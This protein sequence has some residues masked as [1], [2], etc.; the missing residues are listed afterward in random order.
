MTLNSMGRQKTVLLKGRRR[1][2]S[3][4]NKGV[5]KQFV[6]K[7]KRRVLVRKPPYLEHSKTSQRTEN[8][9]GAK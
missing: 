3:K 5:R 9:E 2:V 7:E 6:G 1:F 8:A 4:T